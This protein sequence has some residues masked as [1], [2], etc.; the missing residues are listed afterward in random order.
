MSESYYPQRNKKYQ[1]IVDRKKQG[2]HAVS[3][4][5]SSFLINLNTNY[6]NN[7]S[8]DPSKID[9]YNGPINDIIA[10]A[11]SAAISGIDLYICNDQY[12][13]YIMLPSKS[14]VGP[15]LVI[16]HSILCSS[17]KRLSF[18]LKKST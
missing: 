14:K 2:C 11:I 18:I 10:F 16:L 7:L 4:V 6:S 3:V 12:Y 17:I 13:G 1:L 15:S 5:H 9:N 8:F